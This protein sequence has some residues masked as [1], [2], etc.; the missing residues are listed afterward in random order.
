M[1]LLA[2]IVSLIAGRREKDAGGMKEL[3]DRENRQERNHRQ[4]VDIESEICGQGADISCIQP[5]KKFFTVITSVCTRNVI[6][7]PDAAMPI[8]NTSIK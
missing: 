7:R 4:Q 5:R 2:R 1:A 8:S 3:A 6:T